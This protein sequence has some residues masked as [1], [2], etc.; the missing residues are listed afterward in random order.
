MRSR[1]RL[2][3][4]LTVINA[5]LFLAGVGVAFDRTMAS[6]LT[7]LTGDAHWSQIGGDIPVVDFTNQPAWQR[8]NQHAVNAWNA[9]ATGTGLHLTWTIGSGVCDPEAGRIVVCGAS[10][11][12]L[13]DGGP[14][15]RQGVAR[16]ELGDDHAQTHIGQAVLF[17]CL[18]CNIGGAR[19]Q[20][21]TTHE[22]GHAL[23]LRHS[24]RPESVMYHTGGPDVPD[25]TD[26]AQLRALYGHVDEP[27]TCGVFDARL[28]ALCF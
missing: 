23:G 1:F 16:V 14:L 2:A 9:A 10:A 13:D 4:V 17:E 22:L 24:G 27:D 21:V 15:T 26:A 5:A 18:D 20:V 6:A 19:R 12:S 28:G 3:R 8:A 25:A 11:E 7:R